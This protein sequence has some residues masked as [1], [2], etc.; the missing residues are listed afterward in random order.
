[1]LSPVQAGG[2][3]AVFKVLVNDTRLPL[4]TGDEVAAGLARLFLAG[5]TA[6]ERVAR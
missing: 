2:R 6:G 1:L 4:L 3:A 5:A